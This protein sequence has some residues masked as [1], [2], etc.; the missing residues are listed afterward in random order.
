MILG[1]N[2]RIR[3]GVIGVNGRGR[4]ISSGLA[5]LPECEIVC[6]C[7]VD[8]LAMES[9]IGMVRDITGKAPRGEK[10]FVR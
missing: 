7:D 1:A 9:C 10:T 8:S 3:L 5:K 6:I 4:G 2:D